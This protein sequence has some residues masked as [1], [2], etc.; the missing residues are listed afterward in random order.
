M[1]SLTSTRALPAVLKA[2]KVSARSF[3][4]LPTT[5]IDL[6][7][8]R[9]ACGLDLGGAA[10]DDDA[11]A[12]VLAAQPADRLR[13]WRTASAVTAQVLTITASSSPAAAAC[14]RMTSDS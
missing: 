14:R 9:E 2:P 7:H 8:G 1:M 11:G 12:G 4:A 6:G 3:S 10:G 13:A 5:A